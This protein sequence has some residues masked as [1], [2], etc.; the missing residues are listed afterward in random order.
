MIPLLFPQTYLS[1][2]TAGAAAHF[3]SQLTVYQPVEGVLPDDLSPW[4]QAGFVKVHIPV[5]DDGDRVVAAVNEFQQ[6]AQQHQHGR[7]LRTILPRGDESR[8]P[9]F[10][11]HATAQILTDLKTPRSK[12]SDIAKR[13]FS[14]RL[15]L[16]L[17]QDFDQHRRELTDQ[18]DQ[19][20][21]ESQTMVDQLQFP[22]A[23]DIPAPTDNKP[24]S[25]EK[26][27]EFMPS[28]RL[29]AWAQLFM[30]DTQNR[31]MLLTT[32]RSVIADLVSDS[33]GSSVL[34]QLNLE[35][36]PLSD[37]PAAADSRSSLAAR[38]EQARHQSLP[39]EPQRVP[40]TAGDADTADLTLY[41]FANQSLRSIVAKV[42]GL[43]PAG[44]IQPNRS[45]T[46]AKH[47]VVGLLRPK[48]P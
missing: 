23:A 9:F 38:I 1:P 48:R 14:A 4:I 19:V 12:N 7:D 39:S 37:D 6:W 29:N 16:C 28:E 40:V 44:Q 26:T 11:D 35:D 25:Y 42:A 34:M 13:S 2:V 27:S 33:S 22:T 46:S 24:I 47:A 3:F 20:E 15:F 18:L 32:S 41:L 10:D 21:A 8:P 30:A 45:D 31:S 5:P 17:A 36:L 43:Q